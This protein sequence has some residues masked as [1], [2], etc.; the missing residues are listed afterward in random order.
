MIEKK[1]P[2]LPQ[3]PD[4]C[5]CSAC[6]QSCQHQS[7]RMQ[8]DDE[9]FLYPVLDTERCVGCGMCERACPSLNPYE[10]RLPKKTFAGMNPSEDIRMQSSSGGIFTLLAEHVIDCGGVVF[11]ARFDE[12]WNVVHASARQKEDLRFFRGSKYVQSRIG[13]TFDETKKLLKNGIFVMFVGTPCQI[14]GLNHFLGRDYE[15]LLTIDFI[16]HGVPSPSVWQWYIE[17]Q[18][19]SLS[20]RYWFDRLRYCRHPKAIYQNIE[21][22]NKRKGWKQYYVVFKTRS[23]VAGEIET[24]H[25]DHPYMM[26]FLSDLDLRPS[27]HQCAAKRGKSHSDITIADFWNVHRVIDG[28]DD[29]KGTSLVMVNTEKGQK[30]FSSLACRSQEVDFNQAIQYNPAWNTPFGA[31]SRRDYFFQHYKTQLNDIVFETKQN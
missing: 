10:E 6:E 30:A 11:G 1:I 16:C 5:G 25:R 26:A 23:H 28:F 14:A 18:A 4:C 8:A 15:Q 21:F 24:F 22:R 13:S 2:C 27:C 7:I 29:D 9:G 3:K 17:Q 31:N 20:R 19:K 12:Q